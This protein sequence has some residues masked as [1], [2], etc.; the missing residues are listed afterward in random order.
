MCGDANDFVIPKG[1]D[2]DFTVQIME[3]DSFLPQKLDGF[4]DGFLKIIDM[5]TG[6]PVTGVANIPLAKIVEDVVPAVLVVAEETELSVATL[7]IGEYSI[8]VNDTTYSVIYTVAPTDLAVVTADLYAQ[9][10]VMPMNITATY[11]ALSN[12]ITIK[13]ITGGTA[14]VTYSLNIA[15]TAYVIGIEA[16]DGYTKTFYNDNGYLKGSITALVTDLLEVTRGDA[17]DNFYL[18]AKY[19]GVLQVNFSDNTPNKTA[20]ICEI[21]IV[22]TGS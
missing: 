9:M 21:Y 1:L 3:E 17:V 5:A 20:L 4:L 12:V 18:K 7:G 13:D 15:K 6:A 2:F 14:V 16:I 22:N 19:Q 11:V 8:T 10:T